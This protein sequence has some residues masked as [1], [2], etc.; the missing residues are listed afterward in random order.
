MKKIRVLFIS[1]IVG[2]VYSG[3]LQAGISEEIQ[4]QEI[5]VLT[6][7]TAIVLKRPKECVPPPPPPTCEECLSI[8]I[9]K[10]C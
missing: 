7:P 10:P 3:S 8:P 6:N 1:F 2:L 9:P 5:F 4:N